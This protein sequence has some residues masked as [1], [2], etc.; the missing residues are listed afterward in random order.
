[1]VVALVA[2]VGLAAVP[3][4][5]VA[6]AW[7]W[8]LLAAA[9]ARDVPQPPVCSHSALRPVPHSAQP[10]Q[11]GGR[12]L[13]SACGLAQ[14]AALAGEQPL[15]EERAPRAQRLAAG[16]ALGRRWLAVEP[17]PV[18]QDD[19]DLPPQTGPDSASPAREAGL[20]PAP[21]QYGAHAKLQSPL[22]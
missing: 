16:R 10:V 3:L 4:E 11:L 12:C 7:A 22:P 5:V 8:L 17:A 21:V 13:V 6:A 19:R 14:L 20:A 18:S 1:V 9:I 2:A 15:A